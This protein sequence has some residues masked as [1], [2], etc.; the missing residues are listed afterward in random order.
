MH[1]RRLIPLRWNVRSTKIMLSGIAT[2]SSMTVF[3]N[4]P[5]LLQNE[6]ECSRRAQER[7]AKGQDWQRLMFTRQSAVKMH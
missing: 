3:V 5:L 6:Y 4:T 2:A 1:T 7:K